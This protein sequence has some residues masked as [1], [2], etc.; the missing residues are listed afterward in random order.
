MNGANGSLSPRIICSLRIFL[1]V[2]SI[3]RAQAQPLRSVEDYY[4]RNIT[5]HAE[6]HLEEAVSK[7]RTV[8]VAF[9]GARWH[10]APAQE[11]GNFY[12]ILRSIPSNSS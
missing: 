9:C 8:Q 4:K 7:D 10:L 3:P 11:L 1:L 2:L 12:K 5:R 6:G